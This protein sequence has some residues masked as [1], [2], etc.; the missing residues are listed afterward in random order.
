MSDENLAG[1]T[2]EVER[3]V[4]AASRS[5]ILEAPKSE[6]AGVYFLMDAAGKANRM[7]AAPDWWRFQLETPAELAAFIREHPDTPDFEE[8]AVYIDDTCAKWLRDEKD[9]RD[10]A[11]CHLRKTEPFLW[12]EAA[13]KAPQTLRQADMVRLLRIT[14]RG[15]VPNENLL[16]LV[17][18][19]KWQ[20]GADATG[21]IRHGRESISVNVTAAITGAAAIPENVRFMV[22]V[23]ENHP[24][25]QAI[26]CALEVLA[27]ENAFRLV[28]FPLQVRQALDAAI[29]GVRSVFAGDGDGMP[30]VYRG[31]P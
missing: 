1:F 6:P 29:E 13:A 2:T 26:D 20:A 16:P 11:T 5:S 14:F 18:N 22:P 19:L 12:L 9:R 31:K 4:K 7:V 24:S 30:P 21:D 10:V 25:V 27:P 3:L 17:R 8:S 15:M 23:F 28:P